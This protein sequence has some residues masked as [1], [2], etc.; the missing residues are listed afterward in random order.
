MCS[1]T[2]FESRSKDLSFE[3]LTHYNGGRPFYVKINNGLLIISKNPHHND[4]EWYENTE[5][6]E[7]YSHYNI[8]IT[9]MEIEK[10]WPGFDNVEGYHGNS[11]LAKIVEHPSQGYKYIY[12]G[13]DIY[14]FITDDEI[15]YFAAG[16]GNNDVPYPVAYGTENIYALFDNAFI[17][18]KNIP[19]IPH[20]LGSKSYFTNP[21]N[22]SKVASLHYGHIKDAYTQKTVNCPRENLKN[23]KIVHKKIV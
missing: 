6:P 15:K 19:S 8:V 11:F 2:E 9:S 21:W 4:C 14:T 17:E 23:I 13:N 12:V 16:M 10:Y 5:N 20:I 7:D 22:C 18:I 3:T 1:R